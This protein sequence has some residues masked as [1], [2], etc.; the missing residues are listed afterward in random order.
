MVR[1]RKY[2]EL[3]DGCHNLGDLEKTIHG[4]KKD[5]IVPIRQ[6]LVALKGH[7]LSNEKHNSVEYM[8]F[9]LGASVQ[10]LFALAT[11]GVALLPSNSAPASGAA[12]PG[13][14]ATLLGRPLSSSPPSRSLT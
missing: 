1:K 11:C 2:D 10:W 4:S 3:V 8:E 12:A 9:S 5:F 13:L 14:L 7:L 6:Q